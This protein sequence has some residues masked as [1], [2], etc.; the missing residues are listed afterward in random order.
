[1]A[2]SVSKT[3][4]TIQRILDYL[5]DK[6]LIERVGSDKTGYWKVIE[7]NKKYSV[8]EEI[9]K[10]NNGF[11]LFADVVC[12]T[13]IFGDLVTWMEKHIKELEKIFKKANKLFYK[14]NAMLFEMRVSK[15][16]LCGAL[17]IE[18]H[19]MLIGTKLSI[20]RK[21]MLT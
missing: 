10:R 14:K 5:R 9:Y 8:A 7:I 17:M 16:T 19:E 3:V 11:K 13:E 1:M 18:L 21:V 2:E 4:R 15:R 12:K 20:T 6:G